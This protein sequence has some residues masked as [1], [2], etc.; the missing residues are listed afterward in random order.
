MPVKCGFPG[1]FDL[2]KALPYF[3]VFIALAGLILW[4]IFSKDGN[5]Y[6]ISVAVIFISM[7]PFFF[8][9]ERKRHYAGEIA[10]TAALIA[11]AVISRGVF[12][13]LP[14]IKPIG[15]VIVVCGACLGA[16]R[17]YLIG[18]L[19][20]FISNFLFGQGSWTP[21]QMAALGTVGFIAGLI[22]SKRNA[23]KVPLAAAGFLL[24]FFVYGLIVDFSTVIVLGSEI[25]FN[26]VLAVYLSGAVFNLIFAFSTG[27]F[28]LLFGEIFIKKINRIVNKYGLLNGGYENNLSFTED[29]YE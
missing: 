23:G 27:L 22:F 5:Y 4:Q 20:A 17:G 1:G 6:I 12:Y 8:D 3:C 11:L 2:K 9:F 13:L 19:S 28:L 21:F 7:I 29:L 15:A 26:S 24:I 14:Q 18:A 10:L 16:K 25:S